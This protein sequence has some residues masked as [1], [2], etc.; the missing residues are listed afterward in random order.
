MG[1]PRLAVMLALAALAAG[2]PALDSLARP[3]RPPVEAPAPP[4][5]PPPPGPMGMPSRMIDDAAAYESFL[6]RVSAIAP[7]FTSPDQVSA[8]RDLGASYEPR[9]L[10]RGAVAYGAIA[11]LQ[12]PD[13]VAAVRAAGPTPEARRLLV[14]AFI[15]DP[16]NV[17]VFKGAD[18]AAGLVKQAIGEAGM[19]LYN[20]GKSVKQASYDVQRQAW[21]KTDVLDRMGRLT[22]VKTASSAPLASASDR[23]AVLQRAASGQESMTLAAAPA[24][25][26]YATLLERSLQ[27]AAIAALGEATD[28]AYDRLTYLT[29]ESGAAACL[30]RA[31]LNLYQCLAVARPNYEDI[32][33]TGQHEL[34]DTGECL[35]RGAGVARPQ[36]RETPPPL[37]VPPATRARTRPRRR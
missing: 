31:K 2:F 18:Q 16:A 19:R 11:A 13:F 35:A 29:E 32:F 4:P 24:G 26:P 3:K 27:L 36:A 25:P 21:S 33:C 30:D 17:F 12:A 22:R 7:A 6:A 9:A 23:S 15:A 10:V 1:S 20:V 5:P 8:A 34:Q 28:D 14:N 37:R